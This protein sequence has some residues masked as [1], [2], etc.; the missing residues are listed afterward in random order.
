MKKELLCF[1]FGVIIFPIAIKCYDCYCDKEI[2]KKIKSILCEHNLD[3]LCFVQQ[4]CNISEIQYSITSKCEYNI[5]L[6]IIRAFK[7][8]MKNN[9]IQGY[10]STKRK[11]RKMTDHEYF[12][13]YFAFYLKEHEEYDDTRKIVHN[14]L[15][16][17][18][19]LFCEQSKYLNKN[20]EYNSKGLIEQLEYILVEE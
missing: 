7:N 3:T 5:A 6:E 12:A 11:Y 1:I 8:E 10:Y 20:H 9:C 16:Y 15:Y 18:I 2:R 4:T 17:L 14:K 13:Y 19:I